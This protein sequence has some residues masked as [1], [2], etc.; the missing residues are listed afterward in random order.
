LKIS[1][2]EA[3]EKNENM[4]AWLEKVNANKSLKTVQ[5]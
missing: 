5:I 3:D 2:K 4:G 1:T